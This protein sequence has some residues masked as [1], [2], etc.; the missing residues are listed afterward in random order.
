MRGMC[1][2]LVHQ[3]CIPAP[4]H[5]LELRPTLP[6]RRTFGRRL[7]W[8]CLCVRA[9]T[10]SAVNKQRVGDVT[11]CAVVQERRANA[12]TYAE[13]NGLTKDDRYSSDKI[14]VVYINMMSKHTTSSKQ[15]IHT[16]VNA[17]PTADL[18]SHQHPALDDT[19][20]AG[21]FERR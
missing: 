1:A 14:Y 5:M 9:T 20:E 13:R 18:V 12:I 11:L 6:R 15:A 17:Q 19:Q 4:L 16:S 7:M 21:V 10:H 2:G 8:L 3:S